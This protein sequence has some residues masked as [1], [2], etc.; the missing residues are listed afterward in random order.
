MGLSVVWSIASVPARRV[1]FCVRDS[2]PGS[3]RE[4]PALA[5]RPAPRLE[6]NSRSAGIP[7][8]EARLI[9]SGMGLTRIFSR[10]FLEELQ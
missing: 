10:V 8:P 4:P 3:F 6:T 9:R 5:Q 7:S 2:R 1:A